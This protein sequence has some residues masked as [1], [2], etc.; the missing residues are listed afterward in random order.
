MTAK[1]GGATYEQFKSNP[2]WTDEL[3]IAQ[4]FMLP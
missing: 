4:G 3:L 2:Q 1:A